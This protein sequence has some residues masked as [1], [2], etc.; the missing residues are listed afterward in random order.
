[1]MVAVI[2]SRAPRNTQSLHR[3]RNV[4]RAQCDGQSRPH[5]PAPRSVFS[6]T[7]GAANLVTLQS[8]PRDWACQE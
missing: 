3:A 4:A 8:G 6:H 7:R 5:A 1:M 2:S